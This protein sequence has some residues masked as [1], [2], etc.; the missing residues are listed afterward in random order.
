MNLLCCYFDLDLFVHLQLVFD[1]FFFFLF[2]CVI[3]YVL[4][5][6]VGGFYSHFSH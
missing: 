5:D 4:D 3:I 1:F 6:F 2:F